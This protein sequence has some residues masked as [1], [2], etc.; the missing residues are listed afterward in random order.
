MRLITAGTAMFLPL[1]VITSL[2]GVNV[3]QPGED[4]D[5]LLYFSE[6]DTGMAVI[7]V[8][9]FVFGRCNGWFS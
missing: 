7:A 5:D 3:P 6:Y 2:M 4:R 9:V 1:S 8:G